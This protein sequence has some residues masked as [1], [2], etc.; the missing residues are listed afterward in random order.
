MIVL[1]LAF[2]SFLAMGLPIVAALFGIGTGVSLLEL[3]G[4]VF[5][6]PSYSVIIASG[7]GLGVGVD[8]ALFIVTRFRDELR[9]GA[10]RR[11][12]R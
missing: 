7:I 8:Y 5:P 3:L 11:R 6:A 12:R 10:V 1:L 4:H 9:S 2:G